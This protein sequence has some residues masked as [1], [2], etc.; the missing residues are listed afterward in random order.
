MKMNKYFI[1]GIWHLFLL[2]LT[3]YFIYYYF[4]G[5]E[6]DI[7]KWQTSNCIKEINN[8]YN[9]IVDSIVAKYV[10]ES[11]FY[12]NGDISKHFL[13]QYSTSRL[14]KGDSIVKRK[15]E[16]RFIIYRNRIKNDSIILN[17]ECK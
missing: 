11:Y 15:G 9:G 1:T 17:F 5:F 4:I 8:Q 12:L 6:N 7:K 16:S 14:K 10:K 2:F 13:M 3:A